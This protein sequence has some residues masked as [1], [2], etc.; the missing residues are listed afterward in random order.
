MYPGMMLGLSLWTAVAYA[1]PAQEIAPADPVPAPAPVVRPAPPEPVHTMDEL[2]VPT[3][4]LRFGINFF[5]DTSFS[6]SDRDELSSQFAI[7][8]LGV[9]L[10]GELGESLDALAEVA[11]ETTAD[12]PL[13]DVEQVALRWQQGA[14]LLEVGRFHTDLGFW[15]TAYHHGLWLQTPIAR[16]RALRF[17]DDGGLAPVHW[18]GAHYQLSF[19]TAAGS[20]RGVVGI[21]NGRGDIVDDVR[22]NSDTNN[23][24]AVLLKVALRTALV[25]VG[26]GVIYDLI[27][28]ATVRPALPD[29]SLIELI[30]NAY[31][32]LRTEGPIAIAEA[33]VF[34]H[35]GDNE[36]WTTLTAYGLAGY[37]IT[38]WLTPYVAID[39]IRGA[40]DDPYFTPDPTAPSPFDVVEILAGLR[41][42]TSTWSALK[43]E[44]RMASQSSDASDDE[45]AAAV[46]W[47]FGL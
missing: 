28:P 2:T 31:V 13:A 9:R 40:D 36:A 24:K 26:G 22:V 23:A 21:G 37:A 18:V 19:E 1:Q 4:F 20:L 27:A 46:N 6:I 17:E 41:F 30:G 3:S 25:E 32:S 15:N 47:S 10:V 33:Y 43:I 5:G 39:V 34:H 38:E 11:F 42:E 45:Y 44:A 14:G 12:G 8:T 16:P 35:R 7:G 29:E